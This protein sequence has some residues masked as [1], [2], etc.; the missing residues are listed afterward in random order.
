LENGTVGIQIGAGGKILTQQI[1]GQFDPSI[2][3]TI[4]IW[5][6][7]KDLDGS[8]TSSGGTLSISATSIPGHWVQGN[9]TAPVGFFS[10][11]QGKGQVFKNYKP[12]S[13]PEAKDYGDVMGFVADLIDWLSTLAEEKRIQAGNKKGMIMNLDGTVHNHSRDPRYFLPGHTY[14]PPDPA[15]NCPPGQ[16]CMSAPSPCGTTWPNVCWNGALEN[17]PQTEEPSVRAPK[18]PASFYYPGGVR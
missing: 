7:T 14:Y 4:P 16:R 18:N 5:V 10:P 8:W 13:G 17:P 2:D 9:S 3:G 11:Q 1:R 12:G 6:P 15:H